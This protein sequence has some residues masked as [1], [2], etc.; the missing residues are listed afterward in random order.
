M[1]PQ[2]SLCKSVLSSS[3]KMIKPFLMD[4]VICH[5]LPAGIIYF[6][7][8]ITPP[9]THTLVSAI[10]CKWQIWVRLTDHFISS[11]CLAV[12]DMYP[13]SYQVVHQ[14]SIPLCRRSSGALE[15]F[16]TR[17]DLVVSCYCPQLVIGD[18]CCFASQAHGR[19]S[20]LLTG[21]SQ[22]SAFARHVC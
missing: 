21:F 20:A 5:F 17:F 6:K 18:I 15:A 22:T 8:C 11:C 1:G 13:S 4:F 14:T 16:K 9:H 2:A 12:S 3:L 19:F 7:W 10:I